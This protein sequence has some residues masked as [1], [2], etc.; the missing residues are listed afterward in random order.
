VS[1]VRVTIPEIA[2]WALPRSQSDPPPK[3]L[4]VLPPLQRGPVWKPGQVERLWD[5]LV[6]GLPVGSLLLSRYEK[7]ESLGKKEF[8]IQGKGFHSTAA[9]PKPD[10]HL[11]DGQQRVSAIALGFFNPW[12]NPTHKQVGD[13]R[14]ALWVDIDPT[15]GPEECDF[16]F[17]MVTRSHPWGY[18]RRVP[19]KPLSVS[20]RVKA[21]DE[22]N[23]VRGRIFKAPELPIEAVPFD[24]IAPV[25]LA[26]LLDC[27]HEAN[28]WQALG[29]NIETYRLAGA[30]QA[31]QLDNIDKLLKA[32]P[33]RKMQLLEN[34]LRR[35]V[36]EK[37]NDAYQ[38]ACLI[39]PDEQ[40]EISETDPRTEDP[41]ATLFIRVNSAGT[42]L[43]Q[44]EM[45]Y[46][47][48]KS[49]WPECHDLILIEDLPNSFLPP[50]L[51]VSQ[52]TA[53]LMARSNSE[54]ARSSSESTD[55]KKQIKS[56]QAFLIL[57]ASADW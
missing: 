29:R 6:R 28:V 51:M 37:A 33:T 23:R 46:T 57:L 31:S 56:P 36:T 21:I 1:L 7:R 42:V 27:I 47:L 39:V 40:L 12:T 16:V 55:Q 17:R 19:E 26:M 15:N 48:L 14:N 32:D 9:D 5:S 3:P 13:L 41:I 52:F 50:A 45:A 34:G 24:A 2:A 43:S 30:W 10:W 35:L 49:V 20:D 53:L 54:M 4:A 25:P 11:L 44:E 22:L 8:P 38:I 18:Q